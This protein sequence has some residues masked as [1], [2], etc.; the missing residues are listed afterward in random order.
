M[1][2]SRFLETRLPGK[3]NGERMRLAADES[4]ERA[5]NIGDTGELVESAETISDLTSGS[6][7]TK[8]E[9]A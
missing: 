1:G 8:H 2:G 7:S 6:R 5:F 9:N 3:A 4:F